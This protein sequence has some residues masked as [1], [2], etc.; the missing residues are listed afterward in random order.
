MFTPFRLSLFCAA[1]L[2]LVPSLRAAAP[3]LTVATGF[4]VEQIHKTDIKKEGSWVSLCV[5]EK[6]DLIASD[7]Y[8][9]LW[10]IVPPA[11]G[12]TE[13]TKVEKVKIEAGKAHGLL[14]AYGSL[15]IMGSDKPGEPAG[16]LRTLY[17]AWD[18]KG[19]GTFDKVQRI[20]SFEAP[21]EHGPHALV[22]S[23]NGQKIYFACGNHTP[24]PK[25]DRARDPQV[26]QEDQLLPR[27]WDANGHARG[28]MAPG[29][30]IARCNPDG[31]DLELVASGFRNAYDFAFNQNGEMF[32]YDADMEWDLGLPWY[33]P[34]RVC[35]VTS[36]SEF[37]WRSGSGK[38]PA[39]YE[40]SLPSVLDVGPGSP[41]GLVFGT[42]A[43]FPAKYQ[44]ALF[45]MDWSFGTMYA[46]HLKAKGATYTADKE[47]FIAGQSL[48]LTDL[49]VRPQ[50]G[51]LYFAA[52]GRKTESALYRVTYT[53][54]EATAAAPA[55]DLSD[56]QKL[57]RQIEGHHHPNDP[58]AITFAWPHLDHADRFI[59]FAARIAIENQPLDQ[60]QEKALAE[61]RPNSLREL[62]IAL[63]RL[64]PDQALA[65]KLVDRLLTQKWDQLDTPARL[66]WLRACSLVFI[67]LGEPAEPVRLKL[68]E[69]LDASFPTSDDLVN[70][71]LGNLLV[72]LKSPTIVGKAVEQMYSA[73]DFI[74][75]S[76]GDD[77]LA[78]GGSY[79]AT[80]GEMQKLPSH[81]Q[82]IH[83]AFNLRAATAGWTPE[84]AEKYFSWFGPARSFKGGN[85]FAGYL[86]NARD[87]AL[88]RI[89]DPLQKERLLTLALNNSDQPIELPR[90]K[91]PGANYTAADFTGVT[92]DELRKR[93]IAHGKQMFQAVLCAQCHR[94]GGEFGGN[95]AGGPDLTG[96]GAR[97]TVADLVTAIVDPN[98][99]ISDQYAFT[100]YTTVAGDKVQGRVAREDDK[101]LF[102]I[103]SFLAPEA[104]TPLSKKQVKTQELSKISPMIPG[105]LNALNKD[106]AL[107]LLGFLM[108]EPK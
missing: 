26:W 16:D 94:F 40:D 8:G 39:Y 86:R 88:V 97:Y 50:D 41:T 21:G 51:A 70:R 9:Y 69:T 15:Y 1:A 78:R 99:E 72:Y 14:W 77:L 3:P 66:Q 67:R 31:S 25:F 27:M 48:P 35:H 54:S 82:Q 33:R 81:K 74:E 29:G 12:K 11:I 56:L 52:G 68:I 102:L 22:L 62:V 20:A 98:K 44:N 85:S 34:T 6:G 17:R 32:T 5:D 60:W 7:Q 61:A 101:S 23:P 45:A 49:V 79:G 107:D 24:T 2:S 42:G 55:P 91:G 73:V 58:E 103:T 63:A 59:R 93:D 37:G 28:I 10:R 64:T 57:R 108:T 80:I 18:S 46:V 106:E 71:E 104:L 84:L 30:F 53:G 36:G 100:E 95:G 105:L 4:K 65:P 38:W 43:K 47:V 90:P 76:F 83:F 75:P 19:D 89:A 13:G 87:E 96:A 92:V